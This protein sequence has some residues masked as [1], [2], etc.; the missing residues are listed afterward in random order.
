MAG[1]RIQLPDGSFGTQ[2]EA[3][4]MA[5]AAEIR[6]RGGSQSEISAAENEVGAAAQ[7]DITE[8]G[9]GGVTKDDVNVANSKIYDNPPAADVGGYAGGAKDIHDYFRKGEESN[10]LAQEGNNEAMGLS[11]GRM[12]EDRAPI[13]ENAQLVGREASARQQQ[14]G[15]VDMSRQ[16]AMGQAPSAADAQTSMALNDSM[17]GQ[18]GAAGAA[19]GLGALNGVQTGGAAGVGMQGTQTSIGGGMNRSREVN[20][21]MGTYGGLSGDLRSGD[22]GRVNQTNQNALAGQ[23]INDN[24]KLG[25]AGLAASQGGLG[26]S[27]RQTDDNYFGA[28]QEPAQRQLGYDQEMNSIAAG[29]STQEAAARRAKSQESAAHGRQLAG[30]A[31]AAGLTIGGTAFGGPVGGAA[32]AAGGGMINSYINK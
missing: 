9:H 25:N 22:L 13:A 12:R 28:S 27:M 18:A 14:L 21:A 3:D 29:Q 1:P 16:A 4:A 10:D 30:G 8:N 20:D 19:R 2:R 32:G 7:E 23:S 11:L 15:A 31:I 6:S 26:V 5:K 17:Q 24:W